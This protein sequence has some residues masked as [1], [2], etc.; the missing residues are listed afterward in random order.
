MNEYRAL[1][2]NTELE[3]QI[4]G[5]VLSN[6]ELYHRI[7]S[8]VRAE[9][10]YDPVHARIWQSISA[11]VVN[12]HIAS[13]VSLKHDMENDAGL[14]ELG[15][16][17]YLFNLV[18][19]ASS[20]YAVSDYAAD[21]IE[22][23]ERRRVQTAAE[24]VAASI[25]SGAS[26]GDALST[27]EALTLMRDDSPTQA[28]STSLLAAHTK[29][30]TAMYDAQNSGEVGLSS[31]LGALDDLLLLKPKRSTLIAGATSMGKSAFGVWLAY[32]AARRG[33]GVAYVSLEMGEEDLAN[34]INSIDSR[35]PYQAMDRPLSETLFKKVVEAAKKQESLPI[36]IMSDRVRDIGAIL[37][38]SRRLQ[39]TWKPHGDF[40]G[41]GLLVVD[42]IQL[43][44]GKG[45][46]FEV[47][48]QASQAMKSIAKMM[49]IPVVALAQVSRDMSKRDSTMPHLSDLRGSGDLENDAD[50]VIF[51]HRPAYY[52][53]RKLQ[54]PPSD[55]SE[56]AD[57][58]AALSAC[59]GTMDLIVAKQRMGPIGQC[60]VGVD[61]ACNR[62][63]DLETQGAIDF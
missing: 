30:L 54:D 18:A 23:S 6:N 53:E 31:G 12:D 36:E 22:L 43:I 3:Q 25:A 51:C 49:D 44:R 19:S 47:L 1:P 2:N 38:E 41:L 28:R 17:K 37:S 8:M 33:H 35:V 39:K 46:S 16:P 42:Y 45:T 40:K 57:L 63:W 48:T 34:R 26:A 14:T 55:I 13:P 27:L 5:A 62:F 4:L 52:L 11:R 21:L 61:L 59:K 20:S 56:R 29:S 7:G 24:D 50:N 10:F 32:A 60:R 15:G 58:E 9:H